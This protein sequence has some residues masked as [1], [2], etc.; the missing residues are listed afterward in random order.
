MAHIPKKLVDSKARRGAQRLILLQSAL[1]GGLALIWLLFSGVQAGV[2][3]FLGGAIAV[4][5]NGYFAMRIFAF[6]GAHAVPEIMK[7]FYG[8]EAVK[9]LIT[10]SLLSLVWLLLDVGA[11]PLLTTYIIVHMAFWCAPLCF[12][13]N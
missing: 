5:A 9:W 13:N 7:R 11:L 8:A 1:T 6:T 3:A 4:L 10:V 12:K 2:S